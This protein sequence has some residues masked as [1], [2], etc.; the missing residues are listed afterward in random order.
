MAVFE[1]FRCGCRSF[2]SAWMTQLTE[3]GGGTSGRVR[4]IFRRTCGR[5]GAEHTPSFPTMFLQQR[6]ITRLLSDGCAVTTPKAFA[7]PLSLEKSRS[8]SALW[9]RH[10][11]SDKVQVMRLLRL[12]PDFLG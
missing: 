12:A 9:A 2:I 11:T 7:P 4:I 5:F 3:E 1:G 10:S 6:Q 8:G